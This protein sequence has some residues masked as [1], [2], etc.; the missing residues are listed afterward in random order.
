MTLRFTSST[1]VLIIGFGFSTVVAA[2]PLQ[3]LAECGVNALFVAL[4]TLDNECETKLD[5]LREELSPDAQGNSIEELQAATIHAGFHAIPVKTTLEALQ[6]RHRPFSCIAHLRTGEGHFVLLTDIQDDAVTIADPPQ[7]VTIPRATFL[8]EWT[9]NALIVSNMPL[10]DEASVQSALQWQR[11]TYAAIRIGLG[12]AFSAIVI[13][14]GIRTMKSRTT[15]SRVAR[16]VGVLIVSPVWCSLAS[17]GCDSSRIPPD[18]GLSTASENLSA[19]K[20]LEAST[21]MT[22]SP[23]TGMTIEPAEIDLGEVHIRSDRYNAEF[24]VTNNSLQTIRLSEISATCGCTVAIP[25]NESLSPG[26]STTLAATVGIHDLGHRSTQI[27]VTATPGNHSHS[28][29]I[30]WEGR[31]T[32]GI[33][34]RTL[35]L[36]S[37]FINRTARTTVRLTS[38]DH[39]PIGDWVESISA[40]PESEV[41]CERIDSDNE[42]VV[43]VQVLPRVVNAQNRATLRIQCRPP[44]GRVD[45][46]IEWSAVEAISLQPP[47]VYRASLR[48]GEPWR[49]QFIV[50]SR[51]FEIV[52]VSTADEERTTVLEHTALQPHRSSC[53]L[54][55]MVPEVT[56]PWAAVIPIS[57]TLDDGTISVLPFEF[58][59]LVVQATTN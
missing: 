25:E 24:L 12:T 20:T 10:E 40:Y 30:R 1:A 58:T 4:H 34:P 28:V 57:V 55:G 46:P 38:P 26:A 42:S 21:A 45:L 48:A 9:G 3:D 2:S 54:T 22:E 32:L 47:G 17:T 53:L 7:S 18:A 56:G 50:R 49:V 41:S 35:A 37:V 51:D 5:A 6:V 8:S 59:G 44:L 19:A 16:G 11:F 13:W 43:T 15:M 31:T 33:A 36:G 14:L 39:T 27:R 23:G 29:T 52:S